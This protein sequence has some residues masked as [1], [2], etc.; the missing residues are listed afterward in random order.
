MSFLLFKGGLIVIPFLVFQYMVRRQGGIGK[1]GEYNVQKG[2]GWSNGVALQ[3]LSHHGRSLEAPDVEVMSGSASGQ[4]HSAQTKVGFV[5][6]PVVLLIVAVLFFIC[7]MMKKAKRRGKSPS[8][9]YS[10][11]PFTKFN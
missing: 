8:A 7:V 5:F 6:I 10:S 1:G 9:K 4:G 2:F 11:P 3:M